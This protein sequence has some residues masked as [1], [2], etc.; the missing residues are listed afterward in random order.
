MSNLRK[1]NTTLSE[2]SRINRNNCNIIKYKN[3]IYTV[4][5]YLLKLKLQ[6]FGHLY[7]KS[8]FFGKES[9]VG[10]FEGKGEGVGRG[11]DG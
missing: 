7:E 5:E 11:W 2:T 10:K 6:Y 9:D 3:I 1:F 8:W 4:A